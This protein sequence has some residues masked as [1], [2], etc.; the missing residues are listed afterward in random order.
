MVTSPSTPDI[1]RILCHLCTC[2]SSIDT[3]M[4]LSADMFICQPS[5]S[6]H[7]I[8]ISVNCW[9]TCRS[10][11]QSTL[12]RVSANM[13]T[14]H[15]GLYMSSMPADTWL[16]D[17]GSVNCRWHIS[18]LCFKIITTR[19]LGFSVTCTISQFGGLKI[20]SVLLFVSSQVSLIE[21]ACQ[22]SA[23]VLRIF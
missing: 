18:R 12:D 7:A 21:S 20:V 17:M 22:I 2:R 23:V 13:L 14:R 1:R 15:V 16:A 19:E 11:R 5:I 4:A 8:A 9:L 3:D 6:H 10:T